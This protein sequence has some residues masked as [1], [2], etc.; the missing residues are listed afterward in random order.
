MQTNTFCVRSHG[1]QYF[2]CTRRVF[3]CVPPSQV[4]LWGSVVER[5]LVKKIRYAFIKQNGHAF[6]KYISAP[7]VERTRT[8]VPLRGILCR[9]GTKGLGGRRYLQARLARLLLFLSLSR[10]S[11]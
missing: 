1:V 4:F 7:R 11:S 5:K 9:I 8:C 6:K 3:G 2:D 10:Q